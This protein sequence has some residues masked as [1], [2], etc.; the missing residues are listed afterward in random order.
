M[1]AHN[2]INRLSSNKCL[3]NQ[4]PLLIFAPVPPGLAKN[5]LHA[6]SAC[7]QSNGPVARLGAAQMLTQKMP[8]ARRPSAQGYEAQAALSRGRSCRKA[9]EGPQTRDRDAK[10]DAP[11]WRSFAA[12]E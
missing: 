5:S 2:G 11:T 10:A 3:C 1:P 6:A 4:S 8:H 7:D 9:P 12:S